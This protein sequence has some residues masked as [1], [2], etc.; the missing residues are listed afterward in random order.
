MYAFTAFGYNGA[1]AVLP[2]NGER[3]GRR[4]GQTDD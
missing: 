3:L 1:K 2:A 4:E